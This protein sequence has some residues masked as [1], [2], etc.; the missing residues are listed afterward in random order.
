MRV[1]LPV[2]FALLVGWIF[3]EPRAFAD[4]L[5]PA[6]RTQRREIVLLFLV[7]LF[8]LLVLLLPVVRSGVLFVRR[9]LLAVS[10]G[11]DAHEEEQISMLPPAV[12]VIPP[13]LLRR[14]RIGR[15]APSRR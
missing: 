2:A 7:L 5:R 9:F 11:A 12:M 4:G 13:V 3:A 10:D 8:S 1:A 14:V 15:Y 6:R